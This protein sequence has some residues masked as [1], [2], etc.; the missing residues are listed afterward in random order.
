[1]LILGLKNIDK[2]K[3]NLKNILDDILYIKYIF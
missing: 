2:E 3:K 1:M